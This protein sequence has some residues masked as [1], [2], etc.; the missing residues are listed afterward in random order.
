[1]VQYNQREIIQ[2]EHSTNSLVFDITSSF[3][4]EHSTM[5]QNESVGLNEE[6][7]SSQNA[8]TTTNHAVVNEV[9]HGKL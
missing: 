7:S 9:E 1:M 4:E 2:E 8:I 6:N 3:C 5:F